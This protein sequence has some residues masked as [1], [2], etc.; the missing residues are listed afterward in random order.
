MNFIALKKFDVSKDEE[1]G[2]TYTLLVGIQ[3]VTATMEN[4]MEGLH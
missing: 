4:K 3:I 1:K 2:S